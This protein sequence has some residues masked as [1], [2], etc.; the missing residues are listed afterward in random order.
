MPTKVVTGKT[1][2]QEPCSVP[3]ENLSV[4]LPIHGTTTLRDQETPSISDLPLSSRE[5]RAS[6]RDG[7]P[8]FVGKSY[9]RVKTVHA[10]IFFG[11]VVS[12]TPFILMT[13]NVFFPGQGASIESQDSAEARAE[14]RGTD[15]PFSSSVRPRSGDGYEGRS[16]NRSGYS[17]DWQQTRPGRT[18]LRGTRPAG[19]ARSGMAGAAGMSA[20]Q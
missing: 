5:A 20:L 2:G 13:K 16:G 10:L 6:H 11:L 12:A 19:T 18:T 4:T 9:G 15:A 7:L 1:Q 3:S 8:P 17:T 14:A